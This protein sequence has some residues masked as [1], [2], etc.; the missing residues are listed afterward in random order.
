MAKRLYLVKR[1]LRKLKLNIIEM[2]NNKINKKLNKKRINTIGALGAVLII[3]MVFLGARSFEFV[4]DGKIIG[5]VKSKETIAEIIKEI[6][7][8]PALQSAGYIKEP[9]DIQYRLVFFQGKK[10][11]SDDEIREELAQCMGVT[12][13]AYCIVVDGRELAYLLNR[14]S[15]EEVL[16]R[17]KEPY[18]KDGSEKDISFLEEVLIAEKVVSAAEIKNVDEVFNEIMAEN[19]TIQKYIVQK[20]DTVSEIA[21][22]Y[23]TDTETIKKVN[24][25][26]DVDRIQ[27]GQELLLSSPRYLINVKET[28]VQVYEESIPYEVEYEDSKDIYTGEKRIKV[29]GKEGKKSVTAEVVKINGILEH[30]KVID[31]KILLEPQNEIILR[32]TKERPRTLA[33]GV[34]QRPSRGELTSRFGKRWGRQHAGIDIGVPAGTP[35][36]AADGGK[37]IF[38]GWKGNYGKLVIIDHENGFT[39][40]YGHNDTIKVKV[41]QRVA[42]GDVIGTAGTTG[43][44]TGPHLHFEVRKNG[45]PVDPLQYVNY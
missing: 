14:S 15:A 35:N 4:I 29:K 11:S 19:S 31:E 17:I 42:R 27:I 38:A 34:F 3:L 9:G 22:K 1:Y 6:K 43:N 40:Y 23:G 37:V 36:L 44:V 2:F 33:Y 32:G 7:K 28:A 13:K 8:D 20:G 41:G 18:L 24:P 45:V 10:I 30:T 16:N 25:G 26:L 12:V 39:T 21:E 5:I